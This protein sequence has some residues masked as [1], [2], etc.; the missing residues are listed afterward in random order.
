[1]VVEVKVTVKNPE[2]TLSKDFLIYEPLVL[3]ENDP[4]LHGYIE[5]TVK[6]FN[7]EPDSVKVRAVMVIQ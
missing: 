6:E 5:E 7:D 4:M 3:D 1:M 2:K